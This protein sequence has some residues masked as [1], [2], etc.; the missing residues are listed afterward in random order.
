MRRASGRLKMVCWVVKHLVSRARMV[1]ATVA[2][3]S[4]TCLLVVVDI[5]C[6]SVFRVP[7]LM[8]L[9]RRRSF[10]L[11]SMTTLFSGALT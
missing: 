6:R 11:V 1:L 10:V 5:V 3:L 2:W 7:W 4:L 8:N 9:S